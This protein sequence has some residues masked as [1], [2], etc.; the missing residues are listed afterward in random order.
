MSTWGES[1][2]ERYQRRREEQRQYEN[3]V[4]YEVWRSG[5]NPD[6]I[7]YERVQ[8]SYYDGRD[9]ESAAGVEV[10]R[11]RKPPVIEEVEEQE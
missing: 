2:E 8:E 4:F 10:S 9:A 6:R 3:D 5:G 7:N 11:Q 1:Y